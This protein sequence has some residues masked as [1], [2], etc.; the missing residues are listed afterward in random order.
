MVFRFPNARGL[1]WFHDVFF[2]GLCEGILHVWL[3]IFVKDSIALIVHLLG[4][5]GQMGESQRG[6]FASDLRL[7]GLSG[8]N[9]C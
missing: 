6:D 2:P 8:M 7:C 4:P 9:M 5:T 1:T 3:C